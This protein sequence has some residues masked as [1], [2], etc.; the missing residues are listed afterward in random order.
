MNWN[1][2]F[3]L[4]K[5]RKD[6]EYCYNQCNKTCPTVSNFWHGYITSPLMHLKWIIQNKFIKCDKLPTKCS[7]LFCERY[8]SLRGGC[9][10]KNYYF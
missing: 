7:F 9:K 5:N 8:C 3:C 10:Q 2:N 6:F 4:N 1:I